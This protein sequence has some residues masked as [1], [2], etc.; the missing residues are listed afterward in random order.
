MM[1]GALYRS[2]N[3]RDTWAALRAAKALP[4]NQEPDWARLEQ[5]L[6]LRIQDSCKRL[7]GWILGACNLLCMTYVATSYEIHI[8]GST[9]ANSIQVPGSSTSGWSIHRAANVS[10]AAPSITLR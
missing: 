3:N 7:A 1:R 6:R 2:F 9:R 8:H 10:T 4:L 5:V